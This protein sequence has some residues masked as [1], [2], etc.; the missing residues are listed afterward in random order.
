M[1]PLHGCVESF[2]GMCTIGAFVDPVKRPATGCASVCI[3]A[4]DR[5]VSDAW[6]VAA[7]DLA[8][9][10]DEQDDDTNDRQ[11]SH[12]DA[13]LE[14]IFNDGTARQSQRSNEQERTESE[15]VVQR[16]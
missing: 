13:G 4:R 1:P 8:H 15:R 6:L 5:R 7:H 3:D 9:Q 10:P 12:P 2:H 16:S 14:D 11:D